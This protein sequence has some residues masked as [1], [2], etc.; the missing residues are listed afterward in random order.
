MAA[1]LAVG[2]ART[3]MFRSEPVFILLGM[4]TVA[5]SW[6]AMVYS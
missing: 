4:A 6:F 5:A 3:E 1:I 2:L